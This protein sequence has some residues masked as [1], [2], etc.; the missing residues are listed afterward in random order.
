[1]KTG[2]VIDLTAIEKAK[3]FARLAPFILLIIVLVLA[4]WSSIVYVNPGYVGVLIHRSGGGVDRTPLPV[5]FHMKW[6]VLQEIVEYPVYMQTLVLA[7]TDREGRP[8]NEELNVNSIEGQPTSC[9]VSISFELDPLKV[10]ILYSSFRTDIDMITHGFV[11]QAIRQALQ[12]VVGH[13]EIV[14]FLGKEKASVVQQTQENLQRHLGEY[15]FE[16]KQFT[17]NEIRAPESIV[18]AIEAKNTMAQEALR[19]QNELQKKQFE[20][21][22]RIIEAEGESKAILTRARAQAESNRLLAES[23]TPNLIEYRKIDKWN[24]ALPQVTGGATPF[25]NLQKPEH[26]GP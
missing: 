17:L 16:V 5:G 9:D 23:L 10:P 1:L 19:A 14:N 11:K 24:G 26:P 25:L 13:T 2:D 22:Q 20:A 3:A 7:H 12:E 6:P 21:Q 18:K 8:Y 15:G 4:A